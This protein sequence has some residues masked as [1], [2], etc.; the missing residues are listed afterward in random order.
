MS[1]IDELVSEYP[2]WSLAQ[3]IFWIGTRTYTPETEELNKRLT[4]EERWQWSY[5]AEQVLHAGRIEPVDAN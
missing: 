5:Q 1:A 3:L 2:W 4:E